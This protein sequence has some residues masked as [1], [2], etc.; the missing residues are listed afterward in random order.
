[1]SMTVCL[2]MT[3]FNIV[4][5]LSL[6]GVINLVQAKLR[7]STSTRLVTQ[8]FSEPMT[9]QNKIKPGSVSASVSY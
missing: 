7:Q 2:L 9:V 1:M 6:P 8:S 5:C 4:V 3:A